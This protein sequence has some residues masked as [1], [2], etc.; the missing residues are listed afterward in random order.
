VVT[1]IS[2]IPEQAWTPIRYRNA[3]YDEDAQRWVSE[4]EV[5]EIEF[6]AFTGRPR[7]DRVTAQPLD[8][9]GNLAI[10][11]RRVDPQPR[12]SCLPGCEYSS[13]RLISSDRVAVG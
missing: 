1:A 7:R 13:A 4:A 10:V 11:V 9:A 6:T 5:A 12:G 3:L 2:R 8:G